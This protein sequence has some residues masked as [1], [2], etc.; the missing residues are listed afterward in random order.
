MAASE[1]FSET[2][3]KGFY[4]AN[5]PLTEKDILAMAM[6]TEDESQQEKARLDQR[7]AT[8]EKG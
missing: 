3:S 2:K 4:M 6:A 8:F 7:A 5:G 1:K